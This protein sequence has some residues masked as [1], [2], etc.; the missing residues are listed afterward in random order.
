MDRRKEEANHKT[1]E[2]LSILACFL[3]IIGLLVWGFDLPE[4]TTPEQRARQY[5]KILG[6]SVWQLDIKH[7]LKSE[8]TGLKKGRGLASA[9]EDIGTISHDPWG[10]PYFYS[11]RRDQQLLFIWSNGPNGKNESIQSIPTFHGD[12][13]GFILDLKMKQ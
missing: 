3:F 6:Y 2:V 5:A 11:I 1:F 7:A 8:P 13:L 12:D 4:P 9:I 10:N